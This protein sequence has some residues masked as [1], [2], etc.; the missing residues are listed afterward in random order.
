MAAHVYHWKHGW[1]PLDH[2]AALSKAKGDHSLARTYLEAAHGS[3][4][5]MHAQHLA[6]AIRDLPNV[7]E[8]HRAGVRA[9]IIEAAN[10]LDEHQMLPNAM[11]PKTREEALQRE[12]AYLGSSR[13]LQHF[14]K[15]LGRHTAEAMARKQ[16]RVRLDDGRYVSGYELNK[17]R[18]KFG[19]MGPG[20]LLQQAELPAAP[21]RH[22]PGRNL[23]ASFKGWGK[24]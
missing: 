16:G 24:G 20:P 12:L 6:V 18:E 11:R 9:Q 22:M 4:G 7:P 2:T 8:E 5:I 14:E 10:R 13:T 15:Q 21:T 23:H 3:P 17:V 1:I 19:P